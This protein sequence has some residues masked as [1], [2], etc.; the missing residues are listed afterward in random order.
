MRVVLEGW[1]SG[2]AQ[3]AEPL[4]MASE[5]NSAHAGRWR[6]PSFFSKRYSPKAIDP[7]AVDCASAFTAG[8]SQWLYQTAMRVRPTTSRPQTS[9][10]G[11]SSAAAWF[12]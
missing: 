9:T 11:I 4:Y 6:F 3:D 8:Y 2:S 10:K 5:V 7:F 12:T 1:L